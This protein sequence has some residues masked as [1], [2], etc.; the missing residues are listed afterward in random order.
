MVACLYALLDR[1]SLLV[2]IT[3]FDIMRLTSCALCNGQ[4]GSEGVI[5]SREHLIPNSIGG[6]K[7][8]FGILCKTCNDRTGA[9]WDA[10]LADQLSF[11]SVTVNVKRDRGT[12]PAVDAVTR[13]GQSIR[14]YADGHLT[15]PRTPPIETAENGG[16]RVT[17]RVSTIKEAHVLFRGLKR[18]FPKFDEAGAIDRLK[19][20]KTYISEPVVGAVYIHGNASGRSIVKSAYV[21]AVHAGVMPENCELARDYLLG[22][23]N[24][25]CW[26]FYYERDLIANRPRTHL[27]HCVA[28][29]GNPITRQLL[30]YV[31][32]F[33][34]YRMLVLLSSEYD[35]KALF[36]CYAID[37][38]TGQELTIW[39]NLDLTIDE[40]I[41]TC[42][43]ERHYAEGM[44]AAINQLMTIAYPKT[45]E[46]ERE[47][48]I[49]E[50]V[51][52]AISQLG[53]A[54]DEEI[55]PEGAAE[56]VRLVMAEITPCILHQARAL[57][58]PIK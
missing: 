19:L 43:G 24:T 9:E 49:A 1:S 27:F 53:L 2:V 22:N 51:R 6:S 33:G 40:V 37:P 58:E 11:V 56:L 26:W 50:A 55:G 36:S 23:D 15:Q 8:V 39:P 54:P 25:F 18:K 14:L 35:G 41:S 32:F 47:R 46:R 29:S 5:H 48:V 31:E 38:T 52:A 34:A 20:E 17:G 13:S 28:V 10:I 45:F 7:K 16:I 4:F 3:R 12:H 30:G 57:R 44:S 21:L 42:N